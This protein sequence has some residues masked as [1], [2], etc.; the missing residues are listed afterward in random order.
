MPDQNERDIDTQVHRPFW[1]DDEGPTVVQAK[2]P[3]DETEIIPPPMYRE[4]STEVIDPPPG[5]YEEPQPQPIYAPP[6]PL[7][8]SRLPPRQEPMDPRGSGFNRAR[9]GFTAGIFAALILGGFL[10]F[11]LAAGIT[12]SQI[13]DRSPQVEVSTQTKTATATATAYRTRTETAR[14]DPVEVTNRA[15]ATTTQKV[16]VPQPKANKTVFRSQTPQSCLNAIDAADQYFEIA[17]SPRGRGRGDN[18]LL[19]SARGN[20][21]YWTDQCKKDSN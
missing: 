15:T 9:A 8:P 20:F 10:G 21:R 12:S 17:R 18:R 14:P 5:Y 19:R 3:E 11:L 2:V 13:A 16:I 4:E 7:P 6:P 1:R